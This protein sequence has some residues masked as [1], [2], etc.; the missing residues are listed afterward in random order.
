VR[1][2]HLA[3][4]V[5][6]VRVRT[7][8][9]DRDPELGAVVHDTRA[10]ADGALFCCVRGARVDGHDLA[11]AAVEQGAVA[12]VVD[13]ELPLDVPQLVVDDVRASL[14]P[15]AA[16]FWEHPSRHLTVVGVTG[17]AGKTTMTHLLASVFAAAGR[18]CGVIGTLTGA[19]TTPEAPELQALLAEHRRRGDAAVAME[20]SSHG[21]EL[22]R[23]DATRFAVAVFTN[24][25]QDHLDFHGTM[26]AYFAAKARLFTPA[27]TDRA[28]ICADDPWG[29]RLLAQVD[30]GGDVAT[31]PYRLDDAADLRLT[32]GGASFSW[33]GAPVELQLAGRFNVRNAV[34]AA[35]AAAALGVE[36]AAIAG[37]LSAA[38]PVP[39]RFEAVDAGQ[40]FT[41]IV[42]Y[43]HKPAALD[44]ALQAA[45][46]L[47]A[48]DGELTVVFGCGGDRDTAK[49]P[50]MGRVAARLADRVLLTSDNPRSEDPLA[51]IADI[52]GGIPAGAPVR[53]EPDRR[54][55]IERAIA[56]ARPG[57][58]VV[59]AG[60]GHETT[61]VIGDRTVPFDDRVVARDAID[62]LTTAGAAPAT[63]P[64]KGP[65]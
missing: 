59:V 42:D 50:L 14:G 13:H 19:R 18:P 8:G 2:R 4:A 51:I 40:P 30:A 16:A 1:L 17:T 44:Q 26:D 61:Q 62:H 57:G 32:P 9:P 7:A 33:R 29:R 20:V 31:T 47:V 53:T 22:G 60:K 25:S 48:G 11:P 49:R 65:R 63:R 35:T 41:V 38:A 28:V 45:R 37:G 15:V 36:P 55:A 10:V 34:G 27:F 52:Q 46:E 21:L 56:S 43:S 5:E 12:L 23:V 64:T 58:V 3:A 54:R 39:G 24:L 6:G